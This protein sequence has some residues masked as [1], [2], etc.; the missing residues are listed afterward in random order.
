MQTLQNFSIN[1]KQG[2]IAELWTCNQ[3]L[4]K[5]GSSLLRTV[6][7]F[8]FGLIY[9]YANFMQLSKV[10]LDEACGTDAKNNP[11]S[12]FNTTLSSQ[13]EFCFFCVLQL[14]KCPNADLCLATVGIYFVVW[15]EL[16]K[17][18][19]IWI[20]LHQQCLL[21]SGAETADF[22]WGGKVTFSEN[23]INKTSQNT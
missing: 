16:V 23:W 10:A 18:D 11:E 7:F 9:V 6:L 19:L 13:W 15:S 1:L 2:Q 8:F 21:V 20:N 14:H 17:K 4:I 5:H 22:V 3:S 12:S